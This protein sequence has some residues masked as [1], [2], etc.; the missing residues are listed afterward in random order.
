MARTIT[1]AELTLQAR[2]AADMVGSAFVDDTT[3]LYPLISTYYAELYDLLVAA[4]GETYFAKTRTFDTVAGTASYSIDSTKPDAT[5]VDV[6]KILGVDVALDANTTVNARRYEWS[7][8]N[9]YSNAT[10]SWSLGQ[11]FWYHLQGSE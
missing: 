6:Y 7:E 8:R 3:E 1:L 10:E 5:D 9:A 4:Y 11:P 2:Q